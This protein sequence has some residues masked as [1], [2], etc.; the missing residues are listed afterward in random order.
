[1]PNMPLSCDVFVLCRTSSTPAAVSRRHFDWH[2]TWPVTSHFR[3]VPNYRSGQTNK[4]QCYHNIRNKGSRLI[5]WFYDHLLPESVRNVKNVKASWEWLKYWLYVWK[6]F[7]FEKNRGNRNFGFDLLAS[8]RFGSVRVFINRN[9]TEIRFPHILI[10][11]SFD[12]AEMIVLNGHC[13]QFSLLCI[14]TTL[15]L[16]V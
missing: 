14:A 2:V 9:R 11:W 6:K 3:A 10:E 8:V 7:G 16:F 12:N 5:I 13:G 1:M 15:L 4:R